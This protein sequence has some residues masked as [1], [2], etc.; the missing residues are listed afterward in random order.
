MKFFLQSKVHKRTKGGCM[1]KIMV[2]EV[3]TPLLSEKELN[4]LCFGFAYLI[5]KFIDKPE[6]RK[7]FEEWKKEN[8]K[9]GK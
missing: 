7:K 1:K 2:K 6:N 9:D 5:R 4:T 3:N 8:K